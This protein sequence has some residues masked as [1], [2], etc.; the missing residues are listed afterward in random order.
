MSRVKKKKNTLF[1]QLIG[2]KGLT[3]HPATSTAGKKDGGQGVENP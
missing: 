1:T 2:K 3:H